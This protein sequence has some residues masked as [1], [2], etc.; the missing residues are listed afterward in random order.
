M[1]DE[2]RA[3]L[4]EALKAHQVYQCSRSSWDDESI[5]WWQCHGCD[6][7]SNTFPI[8]G[9]NWVVLGEEI[10]ANHQADVIASLPGVAVI[11]LPEATYAE[12][13]DEWSSSTAPEDEWD[14][15][16]DGR[17][18]IQVR[19]QGYATADGARNLAAALL[20]AAAVAEGEDK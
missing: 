8:K 4:T 11:Q 5:Q 14:T 13:P 2:L 7:K 20:A 6:F 1:S 15:W 16:V 9:I 19:T 18:N 10:A 3:V 17:G 12:Y